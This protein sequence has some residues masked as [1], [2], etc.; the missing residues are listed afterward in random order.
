MKKSTVLFVGLTCA[1]IGA[2]WLIDYPFRFA[3][4]S[5]AVVCAM[6]ALVSALKGRENDG[7]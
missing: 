1:F 4:L 7:K 2:G 6:I 5:A 3:L